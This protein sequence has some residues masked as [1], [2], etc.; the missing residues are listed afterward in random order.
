MHAS[1]AS[2]AFGTARQQERGGDR[3]SRSNNRDRIIDYHQPYLR[4]KRR[5]AGP[6]D[7][8]VSDVD[9]VEHRKRCHAQS[10]A[11][12]RAAAAAAVAAA[13]SHLRLGQPALLL[14]GTKGARSYVYE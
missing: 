4:Q 6:V 12:R 7:V 3:D 11:Y 5:L 13:M 9:S 2:I 1:L 10:G 8:S 14:A